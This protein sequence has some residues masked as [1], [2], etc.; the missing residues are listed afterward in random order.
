MR[1]LFQGDSVTDAGRNRE[2]PMDLGP[3]YA[4]VAA[5]LLRK[6]FPETEFTFFNRGIGGNRTE[7]LVQRL[8]R[9]QSDFLDLNPDIVTILVGVNDSWHIYD[10]CALVNTTHE[11]TE[12]NYRTVLEAL[13]ERNIPVI[14]M[15]PFCLPTPATREFRM[16]L[17]GKI[18]VIRR[19][20]REYAVAYLPLDGLAQAE[21][22]AHGTLYLADD[23][24]H[25]NTQGRK[26]LGNL[27]AEALKPIITEK[28]KKA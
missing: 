15:E 4:S 28:L 27:V 6:A 3:G 12:Q 16:D 13:K 18:E 26:W 17:Y 25:P 8:Q 1:I 9:L 2:D 19:L 11:M 22:V 14:M 5:D 23:G 21:G 24:I 20:A 7:H 10:K